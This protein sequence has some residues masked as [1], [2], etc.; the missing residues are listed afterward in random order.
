MKRSNIKLGELLL[1]SNKV[2]QDQLNNALKEQKSTG[3][4]TR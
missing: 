2:T 3:K 4:K 1:Y